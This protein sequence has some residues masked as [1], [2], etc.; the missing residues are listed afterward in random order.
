[1]PL[2]MFQVIRL[3]RA[4]IDSATSVANRL[5]LEQHDADKPI[6]NWPMLNPSRHDAELSRL[7]GDGPLPELELQ[8]TVHDEEHLIF[9]FMRVPHVVALKLGNLD[10]L[11]IERPNYLRHP[12]LGKA[13]ELLLQV[14]NVHGSQDTAPAP[15][16]PNLPG[17]INTLSGCDNQ[18]S[19]GTNAPCN[20]HGAPQSAQRTDDENK[21]VAKMRS[22]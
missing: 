7:N 17:N 1:M 15:S 16:S 20:G 2:D 8:L 22:R 14:H 10:V 21:S 4:L 6:R 18:Q 5:R 3:D 9:M 13:I 12:S 19:Q 11:A